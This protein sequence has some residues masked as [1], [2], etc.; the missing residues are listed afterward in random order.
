MVEH[1]HFVFIAE[2]LRA[3]LYAYD[4]EGAPL[5]TVNRTM[6]EKAPDLPHGHLTKHDDYPKVPSRRPPMPPKFSTEQRHSEYY[7]ARQRFWY[8]K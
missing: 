2:G 1:N 7:P 8:R 4:A 3:C 6:M 5:E